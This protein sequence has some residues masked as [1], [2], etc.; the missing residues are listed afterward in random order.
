MNKIKT[1]PFLQNKAVIPFG[2]NELLH[3]KS[4]RVG[5][6]GQHRQQWVAAPLRVIAPASICVL[7]SRLAI[8]EKLGLACRCRLSMEQRKN[9]ENQRRSQ[10]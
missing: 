9:Q 6:L 5:L 10:N 8:G 2:I 1:P 7:T 3:N 4:R